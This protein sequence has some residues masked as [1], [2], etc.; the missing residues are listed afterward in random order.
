MRFG[1]Q[2]RQDVMQEEISLDTL[3][4][5]I[6]REDWELIEV[7]ARRFSLVNSVASLKKSEEIPL[8]DLE[9]ERRVLEDRTARGAEVGLDAELVEKVFRLIMDHSLQRQVSLHAKHLA[10]VPVPV[11]NPQDTH[12]RNTEDWWER[13][14]RDCRTLCC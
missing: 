9:R 2:I 14:L 13:F 12:K 3:R 6:D 4:Q 7:L 5:E 8:R 10:P 11:I 1:A